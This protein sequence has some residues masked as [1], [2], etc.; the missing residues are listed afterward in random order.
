MKW[1]P[2]KHSLRTVR[3]FARVAS[4]AS[5]LSV[6]VLALLASSLFTVF[7]PQKSAADSD[8]GLNVLKALGEKCHDIHEGDLTKDLGGPDSGDYVNKCHQSDN[9]GGWEEALASSLDCS[10]NMFYTHEFQTDPNDNSVTE[11]LWYT[12]QGY[13]KDCY[14]KAQDMY[15]TMTDPNGP[16][17]LMKKDSDNYKDCTKDQDNLHVAL[18]CDK[19]MF[20]KIEKDGEEYYTLKPNAAQDCQDRVNAVGQVRITVIGP[21]GKPTKGEPTSSSSVQA[22][23]PGGGGG[24]A[25]AGDDASLGCD[26]SSSPLAWFVCPVIDLMTS[27]IGV[28]DNLI[29]DQLTIPTESIFCTQ[30]SSSND[31]CQA[32]YSAWVSFRNI[33]LGL[34]V[35]VGMIVIISQALGMEI[36]DAYTIRRMLPRILVAA[37]GITLS[38]TLMNFAVTL[39]NDLGFGIR[40]LITAPFSNLTSEIDLSFNSSSVINTF[41]GAGAVAAGA[42]A[43]IPI[44]TVAGGLGVLLSYVATAGLAVLIAIIVL[45]LRELVVIMAII[46]SPI[47]MIAYVMPNTQRVFRLW[48][49]TFSR[50]LLMFPMIAALIAAGRVF[51][52][53]SL[54]D[55]SGSGVSTIFHSLI[56][57]VAYFAPYFMI[58]MTFRA[59]G[60]L[61]AGA[62]GFMQQRAQG[63][64]GALSGFRGNQRQS[65]IA[66]A[67]T[68]GLY[69]EEF[70]KFKRPF[71]K[72]ANG[73]AKYSSVGKMLNLPNFYTL[74]ADEMVP[75][76]LGTTTLG[77]TKKKAGIPGFRR[78]GQSLESQIKRA[79]RDQTVEAVRDLD[80]GYK[81]GRLMGGM[82]KG[83]NHDYMTGLTTDQRQY[84]DDNFGIK[85]EN[86]NVTSYRAPDTYKERLAVADVFASSSK[87]EARE[88]GNEMKATAAEFEK[89]RGNH[90]TDRVDGRL[91]GLLSAAKGGRLEMQ[92]VADNHNALL[93]AGD[94]ES[95]TRETTMLMDALTGKRVSAARGHG[96]WFGEDGTAHSSYENPFDDK[97]ASSLM[98]INSQEIAGSKS[99]DL[100][101]LRDTILVHG[102][103]YKMKWE[104]EG[105]ARRVAFDTDA[106][107][108]PILKDNPTEVERAEEVQK[109]LKTLAQYNYG[110]SDVGVKIKG[111][112]QRLGLKEEDLNWG[113]SHSDAGD[114]P[115]LERAEDMMRRHAE[116]EAQQREQQG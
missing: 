8:T 55:V 24:V 33:A 45:V 74:N 63:A 85:D 88:A 23:N 28:T 59:S 19:Y 46:V 93:R 7:M 40:N 84:L 100:D 5:L 60:S 4:R 99:E 48:W 2:R 13:Y 20:Q 9:P 97:A 15:N 87:K 66:R 75:W 96:M 71:A 109:R 82:F 67:R 27:A 115:D 110:D 29:T 54:T 36:V 111:I 6:F 69:R 57:F 34:L 22:K 103:K 95:A 70:G 86:G 65:R 1:V 32:Y 107:G 83:A 49:E 108:K 43:A 104:G 31:S 78:Y 3:S 77:G 39:S 37:L 76:K 105:K 17:H 25:A 38:W 50:A 21:D 80:I 91:L 26:G 14:N 68:K 98:R 73:N 94:Q 16:C 64:Y 11:T 30:A 90:E 41:F 112:W 44:W 35:I 47:A 89:Y 92:D 58:P 116:E 10:T 79:N 18:G 56:G 51:A 62:N 106:A 42:P 102:S 61:L 12:D 81:S 72:D 113:R 53:I 114:E 101:T 52:A